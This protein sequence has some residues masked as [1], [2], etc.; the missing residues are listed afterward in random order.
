[1]RARRFASFSIL[2]VLVSAVYLPLFLGQVLFQR[3]I[4]RW[5]HP[6]RGFLHESL[7]SGDSPLWNPRIGLGL[8]VVANPLN[9]VSYPPNAILL[10]AHSPW[11]TSFFL[12]GHL[13]LGAI[14]MVVLARRLTKA[15]AVP[16]IVAGLAW[17]LSG[18][19]TSE[20]TAGP[21]L[22][23]AAYIPWC[24]VG[25]LGLA[26]AIRRGDPALAWLASAAWAAVPLGLCFMTG[27]VFF[28]FL[29]SAFALSVAIGDSIPAGAPTEI[30]T[31][32]APRAW[33]RRF[34]TGVC[35]AAALAG[36]IAAVVLVPAQR[37]AR[38][39]A[40]TTP[41]VRATAEVGSFHPWRMAEMIAPGAMGDPY[42]DYVGGPWVGEPGLGDRGLLYGCY[43]GASVAALALLA[44]G[45]GRRLA[46]TL[47][48]TAAVALLISF[49]RHT[50]VH[51]MI[52]TLIPPLAYMRGPEK[53]LSI[54]FACTSLLAG[55][56]TMRLL[57]GK[58]RLW[59]RAL[60][61]IVALVVLALG[62]S[63]FPRPLAGQVLTSAQAGLVF[64]L[65]ATSAIWLAGRD[66][67]P[68]PHP[69][70]LPTRTRGEG[71]ERCPV[72]SRESGDDDRCLVPSRESGGD[73]R[74]LVPSPRE[75]GDDDRCP[76]PSPRESGDRV[77]E[78][79]RPQIR[80]GYLLV[81]IVLVDLAI[82]VLALQ[83]F[84]P[85][86]LLGAEPAA[87]TAIRAD[88]RARGEL[89]PPRVYRAETVDDAIAAVAPPT[90]VAQVQRNLVGT[91]I[92]NH[93]GGFGIASVPGYDAAMPTTL[94]SLW[95]GGKRD[96][97]GLLRLASV[98]YAVL[99][100]ST[101]DLPGLQPVL[102]PI[103]GARLYRV[104]GIL[105][106]V[107]LAQPAA[108]LSDALALQAVFAPDVIAGKR[109]ILAPEPPPPRTVVIAEPGDRNRADD[110]GTC[111]LMM[112]ANTR[113]EAE[114]SANAPTLAVFVE[115][116][117]RGWSATLDGRP[118]PVLRANLAMRAIPITPGTHRIVLSFSPPGLRTG[119]VLS[120]AGLF[121]LIALTAIGKWR[122][123]PKT[124]P[125][126]VK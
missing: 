32:R 16:A 58:T 3:D 30:S 116:F 80:V 108:I 111:H 79:G 57:E 63:L 105:P 87:A 11:L 6:A 25:F 48:I 27:E 86:D 55:L 107:Y 56:G 51:A 28:P 76:V 97:V 124:G 84:G 37:S 60:A 65:A 77:R 113:I 119:L 93:A 85:A 23:A 68:P 61:V 110:L 90:T 33:A 125:N 18:Y 8:S 78:R 17:A 118:A 99:P 42:T 5:I 41:L 122:N 7:A 96:G 112:F 69:N 31:I 81:A 36:A 126:R 100:S 117:D 13:L 19:T 73:D 26:R 45:R 46:A 24:A 103:P 34:A 121:A 1:M 89:A 52:R 95:L 49:G 70:P 115:Q 53:Y 29:A 9:Q 66:R 98:A 10:L 92:D 35:C 88:A 104:A 43:L 62:A 83:N 91:L 102:D 12:F 123:M 4:G 2:V 71:D 64:A 15:A 40:R 14:G 67:R 82:P 21:R 20:F 101:A 44:F 109:V 72:P 38:S 54:F 94:S 120:I 50:P 74:C 114:C 59:S 39:T 106:R 75:S 22:A 47:G